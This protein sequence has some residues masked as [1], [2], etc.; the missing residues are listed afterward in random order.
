L[1]E[2]SFQLEVRSELGQGTT[3]TMRIPLRRRFKVALEPSEAITS[4]LGQ[5]ASH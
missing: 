5:L 2:R 4:D 3:V 1:F